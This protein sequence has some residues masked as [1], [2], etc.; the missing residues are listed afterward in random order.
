MTVEDDILA[1]LAS[2]SGLMS[3]EIAQRLGVMRDVVKSALMQLKSRRSL[4]QDEAYRWWLARPEDETAPLRCEVAETPLARLCR[5]Y[6]HCLGFDNEAGVGVRARSQSLDYAELPALPDFDSEQRAVTTFPA[7]SA[8]F[9]RL[10]HGTG[11]QVPYLGY[12]VRLRFDDKENNWMVEPL[13]LFEF[14]DDGGQA[15]IE[16]VLSGDVPVLN[17]RVLRAFAAGN[18]EH[19]M[20]E[21]AALADDL[22]L[23][24]TAPP[25]LDEVM[26]RLVEIRSGWDWKEEMNPAALSVGES[27][28]DIR[29]AGIYNRAVVFGC[30]GSPFTKGLEQ[31]L[32]KLQRVPEATYAG[33]ALGAW[34]RKDVHSFCGQPLGSEG[35]L[36]PLP[37][38]SEQREAIEKS[39]T[40]PLTIIAGPPGTGKSQVVSSILINA[41][42]RG[43]RVLFT[44]KNNK[45]VD[46]VEERVN[47]LGPRP[48][49]IRL[50]K[51][52]KQAALAEYLTSLLASRTTDDD[53]QNHREAE[54]DYAKLIA[55]IRQTQLR[56]IKVIELRNAVDAA[57]Q[58]VEKLRKEL[59]EDWFQKFRRLDAEVLKKGADRLE[60]AV[61]SADRNCQ[62]FFTRLFW[63]FHRQ[64]RIESL[65]ATAA[66]SLPLLQSSNIEPAALPRTDADVAGWRAVARLLAVRAEQVLAIVHYSALLAE[67][68][69]GDRIE[70]LARNLALLSDA[71]AGKSMRVWES[72]LQLAPSRLTPQD[73]QTLGEF[74][75]T[76]QLIVQANADGQHVGGQLFAR[77]YQLFP[78]LVSQLPCWAVT[79]LS[80]R[81]VPLEAGFFDLLVV[82]EASQCDIA[83][84][85]PLLYRTKAAVIIGD[86]MQL[87]HI[88]AISPRRD[89]QLLAQHGIAN[90]QWGFSENSVFDLASPLRADAEDIVMLRD[91]HRSHGAIIGFSN[92]QFYEGRLRVATNYS[93]LKL[94]VGQP[95]V[96]WIPIQGTVVCPGS[97]AMI[98]AEAQAVVREIER[99]IIALGFKG[100]IGVVTPFQAQKNR[101]RVILHDH[102]QENRFKQVLVDTVH[103][104]QGDERDAMIF[105]PVISNGMPQGALRFLRKTGNLFNVAITRARAALVVVGDRDAA[106]ASGIEHLAKFADYVAAGVAHTAPDAD[107]V[108]ADFDAGPAYPTVA[109]PERVSDWERYFYTRLHAAGLRPIPQYDEEKYTLDFALIQGHRRLNIEVDGERY[110]RDWNG[111][112]LR[113]DQLRNTRLIEL[114]W[115]VMRF[116][117]Y[118]LRDDM[119]ACIERVKRWANM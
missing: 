81:R 89:L 109:H 21:A 2:E 37:L 18:A 1:L 33:T 15:V 43:L 69:A 4:R 31:E 36:E 91:H 94:P 9:Q 12:P 38:N 96:R 3:S 66:D 35:L 63:F 98:E 51:S 73:C 78:K 97:G 5:Y 99:L 46:V 58:Q 16:P 74:R 71:C 7:V 56:A 59:G 39:L 19:V 70:H 60:A 26:A 34:L 11:R 13:L 105:S 77:Y 41:A 114:G 90:I 64:A 103:G 116:W 112:L 101:I 115:E 49:L 119:E 72:W 93:R 83:S 28:A 84:I 86:P 85:L 104:F 14:S 107:V 23:D 53:E 54:A 40:R 55:Q 87:K 27:L 29:V 102:P 22:G 50:G 82:D 47:A 48:I 6:L 88:S 95:A 10:R 57:E 118:E 67:L 106:R 20:E 44:S 8:L 108:P 61:D 68:S 80:A 24:G 92:E 111:E 76:L 17:F 113:R 30:E 65:A 79:S 100:S 52:D 32:A 75:A 42:K 25:D 45:A 62:R 117:V 110:H